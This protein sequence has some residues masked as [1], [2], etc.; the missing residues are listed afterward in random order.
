MKKSYLIQ[1]T[2]IL[3]FLCTG[4][5]GF[6]QILGWQFYT[7]DSSNKGQNSTYTSTIT[8]ANLETS[9]LTRGAGAPASSSVS[10]TFATI[11]TPSAT[12]NDAI[13]NNAYFEFTVKP[14]SGYYVSLTDLDVNIR[15]SVATM[16]YQFRYSLD[17][18]NFTDIGSPG[19]LSDLNLNGVFQNTI[20]LAAYTN[21]TNVPSTTTITFRLYGWGASGSFAIGKSGSANVNALFFGGV[22]S[23]TLSTV[24][25]NP[26]IAGWEF[27]P[28]GTGN[29]PAATLDATSKN[30]NLINPVLSRGAG[31]SV[32]SL[33]F[34]YVS[35]TTL[36]GA[37]KTDSKTNN[38]YFQLSI[39]PT[40]GYKVSLSTLKYRYRTVA[41]GAVKHRWTYSIDGGLTF[42]DIGNADITATVVSEGTDY[43][44][45]LSSTTA[46]QNATST[47]YLRMYVWGAVNGTF[48]FGRILATSNTGAPINC[49][50][51]RGLVDL[52]PNLNQSSV[53][54]E[55]TNN[56]QKRTMNENVAFFTNRAY[57]AYNVPSN[58]K[59]YEFLSSDGGVS[60]DGITPTGTII[61][62]Q[63]GD[64]YVIARTTTG[65]TGWTLV[66][67]TEFFY[68]S[69]TSTAGI[70]V[71]KKAATAGER[72]PIPVVDNF[73]E[74]K[75]FAKTI[76]YN[77]YR[78]VASGNWSDN[79]KWEVSTDNINW[80]SAPTAPTSTVSSISIPAGQE[81]VIDAPAT[82]S[83]I[84][85]NPAAKL[86]V[87]ATTFNATTLN[88]N[89]DATG[90]ATFIDNGTSSIT[91]ANV[92]QYLTTGRNWYMSI[93]ISTAAS[94]AL[95]S[96]SSV[97]CWDET[98]G[99][100]ASPVSST[101]NPLRGYISVNTSTTGTVT[102]SGALNN[103]EK[104][105]DITR[106]AGKTK[107]GFN[108]VGNP[109]PSYL[110]WTSATANAANALTTIWYRTK[111]DGTY[112]FH[113]YN[114]DGAVGTPSGVT[115]AI[116]PMQAF[117]VR[118]KTGG[119]R[120]TFDNTMRSHGSGSN[121]LKAPANKSNEQKLIRLQV[122]NGM[123]TDETVVYFNSKA[124]DN[125]DSFDSPKMA[126][127]N[128][129]VPEIYTLAGNEELV[130][131]G[132]NDSN[133]ERVIPLGFRS[134]EANN[135]TIKLGEF[136]NFDNSARVLLKDNQENTEVDIT[137]DDSYSFSSDAT[138]T[139]TRFSL[140]LKAKGVT[141]EL[142]DIRKNPFDVQVRTNKTLYV[143]AKNSI[144]GTVSVYNELGQLQEQ[145]NLTNSE[146]KLAKSYN[147]GVYFVKLLIVGS[148]TLTRKVVIK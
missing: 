106:T 139:T 24:S 70:S 141:T 3:I 66:P 109:Y 118:A 114:A 107:E 91:N 37:T 123:N 6:G 67:G 34:G 26:K 79:S 40:N 51:V 27:S 82:A 44:L 110:N 43:Q 4:M 92:Q 76:N 54:V 71:F 126:N 147:S 15:I 105:I 96:A 10:N 88:L 137:S 55:T 18:T 19:T 33:N 52:L 143:F 87:N 2:L 95:S 11:F 146:A 50:Y 132:L 16:Y 17:G 85:V 45:D 108:L 113:T 28:Y 30:S 49:I 14:K 73:Q 99:D 39:P 7:A 46:L 94:S 21:L 119:G 9:V 58:L 60:S 59:N 112:A 48:G 103:G 148:E 72:V 101:L 25:S 69:G 47:I 61:P 124:S 38:E 77:V 133:W 56:Y 12:L 122:S 68:S 134:G 127:N 31:L 89:S 13:T 65:V 140:I 102:F 75:P 36:Q 53:T 136:Q 97:V 64:V 138:N 131:N 5:N 98:I 83:I 42:Y 100:W 115:G 57:T 81:L 32:S 78:S 22:V 62:S 63:N 130:I 116:P 117:W 111:V 144:E 41:T 74:A 93:P 8:D 129:V 29:P 104:Y 80:S 142:L 120:L 121:P 135:F 128:N 84:T 145:A 23:N 125:Y 1:F 20:D 35:T 86:T 90:T